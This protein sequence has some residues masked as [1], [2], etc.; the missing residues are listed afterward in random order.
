M[1]IQEL[2]VLRWLHIVCMV[3]W[4][5]GE[6]GVFNTATHVCNRKLSF[7]ER[8]RHMSTAYNIDI[9]ARSG[10]ILLLPL[11]LHMG[12][13]WGV[14]PL[15]GAW[16]TGMWVLAAAWW[17]LCLSAYF[18]H[19]SETGIKLTKID[20]RIR[21][22]VIPLLFITSVSSL[23]GHGPFG[24]A[25]GQLWYSAKI[26]IYAIALCI[27]LYLRFVM[28]A[29][30]ELFRILAQG[31]NAEAEAQL[32]RELRQS[33]RVAYFYWVVILSVGFLGATKP[34]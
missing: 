30:Q 2:H 20:E 13:L 6:W 4:L 1:E 26:F 23:L 11:G 5:G 33:K 29:W 31:P 32:E 27:G 8:R 10:I 24:G 17:G 7:E 3:Y 9:L 25:E 15:G 12:H 34:F 16:L 19:T 18:T 22:V 14:Q 28:R 21:F